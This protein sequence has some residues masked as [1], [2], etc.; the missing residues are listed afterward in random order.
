M[1]AWP[2]RFNCIHEHAMEEDKAGKYVRFSDVE[3]LLLTNKSQAEEIQRLRA[4]MVCGT[5]FGYKCTVETDPFDGLPTT[6]I[7]PVCQPR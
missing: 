1:S 4:T 6:E 2:R 3:I 5:C 7:C